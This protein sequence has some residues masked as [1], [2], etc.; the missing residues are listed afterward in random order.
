MGCVCVCVCVGGGGGEGSFLCV[1]KFIA[2]LFSASTFITMFQIA[3]KSF[4]NEPLDAHNQSMYTFLSANVS[5]VSVNDNSR[6]VQALFTIY[7]LRGKSINDI[8]FKQKNPQKSSTDVKS[9]VHVGLVCTRRCKSWNR[10]TG[11]D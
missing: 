3:E 8:I 6:I 1:D 2:K 11:R 5:F 4:L 10:P 7:V 9:L